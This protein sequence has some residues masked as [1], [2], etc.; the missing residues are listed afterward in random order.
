MTQQRPRVHIQKNLYFDRNISDMLIAII[1]FVLD[2]S[3]VS[4][5][6]SAYMRQKHNQLGIVCFTFSE[7]KSFSKIYHSC[8]KRLLDISDI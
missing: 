6:R 5:A 4:I 3:K 1:Y 7:K 8:I 2:I